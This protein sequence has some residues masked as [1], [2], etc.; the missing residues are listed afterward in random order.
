MQATEWATVPSMHLQNKALRDA[1]TRGDPSSRLSR[2]KPALGAGNLGRRLKPFQRERRGAAVPPGQRSGAASSGA[3]KHSTCE[4]AR[5]LNSPSH[6]FAPEGQISKRLLALP[7]YHAGVWGVG[8]RWGSVASRDI[9]ERRARDK[10]LG[11]C[12]PHA[13]LLLSWYSRR[14][15]STPQQQAGGA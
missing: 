11:V 7:W 3:S 12:H 15:P 10:A 4:R 13:L 8:A 6:V 5:T 9:P 14:F 2:A 1:L